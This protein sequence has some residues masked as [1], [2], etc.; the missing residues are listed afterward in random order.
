MCTHA[1]KDGARTLT[2]EEL[3]RQTLRRTQ[4][5]EAEATE[6]KGMAEQRRQAQ[7]SQE[8]LL[9]E[10][11]IGD[12]SGHKPF[13][14]SGVNIQGGACCINRAFEQ[15]GA[16]IVEGMREGKR[17]LNPFQTVLCQGQRAKE[18]RVQ[19]ERMDRGAH[20]VHETRQ[21]Q[22][23]RAA[24]ATDGIFRLRSEEHTS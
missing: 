4:G 5:S 24:A 1:C 16:A 19:A 23:K 18:R 15:D 7:R 10:G 14:G 12:K 11:P 17:R 8:S 21:C 20:I 13:V 6:C 3:L 9:N 22:F 2:L